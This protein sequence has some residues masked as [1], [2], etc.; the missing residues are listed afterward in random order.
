[1]KRKDKTKGLCNIGVMYKK[2]Q[3][4]VCLPSIAE[5][6]KGKATLERP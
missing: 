5:T 1:M 4:R 2:L 3:G 6:G